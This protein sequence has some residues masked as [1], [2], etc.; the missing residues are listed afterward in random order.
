MT[1]EYPNISLWSF[2]PPPQKIPSQHKKKLESD[3]HLGLGGLQKWLASFLR[4]ISGSHREYPSG[5]LLRGNM[6][7]LQCQRGGPCHITLAAA[8]RSTGLLSTHCRHTSWHSRMKKN[9]H[10]ITTPCCSLQLFTATLHKIYCSG[11][12]TGHMQAFINSFLT[13]SLKRAQVTGMSELA[14]SPYAS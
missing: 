12:N 6:L 3:I 2:P 10:H 11:I 9:K 4:F 5:G 13:K 8:I 7:N 14:I 1:H